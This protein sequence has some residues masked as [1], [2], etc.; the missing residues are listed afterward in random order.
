MDE[1]SL[2]LLDRIR[3]TSDAQSWDRLTRLY[4]P[5]LRRWVVRYDVQDSDAD[6]I[7]QEVLVA[8]L[9]ELHKFQHNEQKGAFRKWLRTILVNRVRRFWRSRRYQPVATG[10]SSIDEMLNQ[11]EVDGSE[12]SGVW[13][14]EHDDHIITQLMR[15]IQPR[16]GPQVWEAFH[17]QVVH[18]EKADLVAQDLSISISAVYKAKSRVLSALRREATG[19]VEEF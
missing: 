3:E 19:L 12:V 18:G 7:V 15:G 9:N 4:A 11:L 5:L 14:R 16:F 8:V 2:S 1:T 17:R 13:N 6:D 10:T